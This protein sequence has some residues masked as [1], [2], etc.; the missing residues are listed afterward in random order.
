M[1]T[2]AENEY[3]LRLDF[4]YGIRLHQLHGRFFGRVRIGL[5]MVSLVAGSAAFTSAVAGNA[6][7]LAVAGLASAAATFFDVLAGLATRQANHERHEA[8]L[9]ALDAR[10][11][12][13]DVVEA[14]RARRE[15]GANAPAPLDTLRE[16]AWD[17]TLRQF[18]HE[19]ERVEL[20]ALQKLFRVIV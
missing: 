20:T 18:G 11:R 19:E 2:T 3:Q 5:G 15:L 9:V 13:T 16:L 17:D 12:G 10:T 4:A 6:G 1:T 14:D 8:E 7:L